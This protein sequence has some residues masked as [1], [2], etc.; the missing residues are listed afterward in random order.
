[1]GSDIADDF[2]KFGDIVVL[3]LVRMALKQAYDMLFKLLYKLVI[4]I[5]N[6]V[7]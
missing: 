6:L 7:V 4:R 3:I 1:M 5:F 2:A